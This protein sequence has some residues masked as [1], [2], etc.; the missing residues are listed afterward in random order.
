MI[1]AANF[2][3]N[4]TRAEFKRYANGLDT[5]LKEYK[6][7]AK[8]YVAPSFTS[9]CEGEFSFIQTSQNIYPT[10]NGAYT[11]EIGLT[12]LDEF[13]IRS[14]IL[15]HCERRVL[16][17]SDEF[18]LKK[19]NFC[20]E[21]NLEIIFCIGEDIN[22]YENNKTLDFLKSQLNKIDLNYNRL[23]LAYEPIYSIGKK[24]AKLEDIKYVMNYLRTL[25]KQP[26][27]YGGSVNDDNFEDIKKLCDGVLIGSASLDLDKFIS[28]IEKA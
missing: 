13:G 2:K 12:H 20:K 17:E 6:G 9:F 23:I 19:F 16:G 14:V 25:T 22:T 21:N 4:K 7:C 27:L 5:F 1:I 11:G 8:V 10:I 28:I 18:L 24:A 3:C 15:G 26:I